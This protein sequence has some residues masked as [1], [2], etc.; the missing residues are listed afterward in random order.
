[1]MNGSVV[2]IPP[3]HHEPFGLTQNAMNRPWK[4]HREKKVCPRRG[5][6]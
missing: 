2:W 6:R 3:N 1:M 4:I 5:M